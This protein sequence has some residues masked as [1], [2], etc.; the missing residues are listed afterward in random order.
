MRLVL[1]VAV[2]CAATIAVAASTTDATTAAAANAMVSAAV[3]NDATPQKEALVGSWLETVTFPES[4][5]QLKSLVTF[6]DDGTVVTSDQGNVVTDPAQNPGVFS[7]GHGAWVNLEKRTFSYNLVELISDLSGNL[8]AY[9]K[10]RG[11]YTVSQS[12][13]NYTGTSH[14]EITD[15]IGNLLDSGDVTNAGARIDVP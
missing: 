9:L 8:V 10:V 3:G 14:Y 7:S 4:G 2:L 11:K 5:R 15:T 1:A 13:N 6:H 12:G